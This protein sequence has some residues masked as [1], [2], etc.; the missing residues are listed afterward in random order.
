[1]RLQVGSTLTLTRRNPMKG[2]PF[3]LNGKGHLYKFWTEKLGKGIFPLH[4]HE[5]P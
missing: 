2:T 3:T 1:M 4:N 5:E